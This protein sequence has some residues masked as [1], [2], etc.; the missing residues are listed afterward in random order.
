MTVHDLK[1]SWREALVG[2]GALVIGM[3]LPLGAAKAQGAGKGPPPIHP[4]AFVRIGAD[5]SVT[6]IVKH[7]EFGQG[8][9]TGLATI[10]AEELDADWSKVKA[11]SA[12]ANAK[13]YANLMMGAQLTGGSSAIANSYEQ[14][15][16][17]GAMARAMLVQAAATAWGVKPAS[18]SVSNGIL[19]SGSKR[20]GFGAFAEAAAKLPMRSEER[21]VG[22]ECRRLCRSRWSPYH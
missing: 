22:K 15:R 21:R 18:I 17:A 2:G 8:P 16:R 14:M 3:V 4:N 1:L 5:D 13:L 20:S 19:S 12:P 7:I 11:V 6:I 9:Y 10:A